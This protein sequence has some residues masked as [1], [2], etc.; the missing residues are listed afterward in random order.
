MVKLEGKVA[1]VTGAAKG[2]G[3]GI[4]SCLAKYGATVILTDISEKVFITTNEIKKQHDKVYGKI[5]DVTNTHQVKTIMD[6]IIT[7]FGKI[8]ILVNNAGI[9]TVGLFNEM[10]DVDINKTF[11]VNVKGV[12][13]TSKTV[14]ENMINNKFGRI[15]SISSVTGVIASDPGF[16]IYGASKGSVMG[17]TK[18]LAVEVGKFGITVNAVLPG[19]TETPMLNIGIKESFPEKNEEIKKMLEA[20]IPLGRVGNPKD[21]GEAVS[22][23]ASNEAGYITGTSITVDGGSTLVECSGLLFEGGLAGLGNR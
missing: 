1:V 12:I 21:V 11:D 9:G 8:D 10:S 3:E 18:S 4:A 2:I 5:L 15:I 7:E 13:N 23:L 17:L 22:F 20:G 6:A 16:S 14:I 19:V